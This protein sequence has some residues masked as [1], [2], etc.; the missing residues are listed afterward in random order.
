MQSRG[1]DHN[2]GVG[3]FICLARF[4]CR[5]LICCIQLVHLV[6]LAVC[7][8]T[9]VCVGTMPLDQFFFHVDRWESVK[10]L[11]YFCGKMD[12]FHYG[13]FQRWKFLSTVNKENSIPF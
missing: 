2:L 11:Q 8:V 1:R 7:Y 12:I 3:K 5:C 9:L 4:V 6:F 13:D 10:L